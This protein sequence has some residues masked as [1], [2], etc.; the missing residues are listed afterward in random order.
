MRTLHATGAEPCA[1]AIS[2][3]SCAALHRHILAGSFELAISATSGS[4]RR[5]LASGCPIP[6]S[7]SGRR[8]DQLAAPHRRGR[9]ARHLLV[10]GK[11][12]DVETPRADRLVT[13]VAAAGALEQEALALASTSPPRPRSACAPLIRKACC[14][15]RQHPRREPC[16][17]ARGRTR[18][19]PQRGLRSPPYARSPIAGRPAG[20]ADAVTPGAG[21][22][23]ERPIGITL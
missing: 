9:R 5:T 1:P 15:P 8:R 4:R 3:P 23:S 20:R 17:R 10:T 21:L 6:V 11:Q 18:V 19:L 7:A 13:R 12:I 14:V 22:S 16:A 2:G